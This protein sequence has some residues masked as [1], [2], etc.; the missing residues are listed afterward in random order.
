MDVKHKDRNQFSKFFSY[1]DLINIGYII[2]EMLNGNRFDIK[3]FFF[4]ILSSCFFSA[5]GLI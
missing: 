5:L 2:I 3:N 1:C 4:F